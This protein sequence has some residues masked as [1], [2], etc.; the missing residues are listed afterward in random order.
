M[1]EE[2]SLDELTEMFLD[3]Q[4]RGC[5]NVNMVSPTPYIPHIAMAIMEAR[6][7]GFVIPVVYNTNAYESI[8]ALKAMD[9][10][11][12]IYL[13]D[14]KYWSSAVAERLSGTPK[15]RPY[16]IFAADAILEMKRQVGNLVDENNVAKRVL[17]M[18]HLV[19]PGGLA[20]SQ[21]IFRWTEDNLGTETYISLMSQYYP[22]HKAHT[23]P[24][25]R[26]K[27][28]RE[29]YDAVLII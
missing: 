19:L 13:P 11:V 14:F 25:L 17:I 8:E 16:P 2:I 4:G 28:R 21:E 6:K 27:I 29:E 20:G 10:L 24:L 9:G 26:R 18:R 7:K 3:L 23:V 22:A 15:G 12:D 1:G 5:H